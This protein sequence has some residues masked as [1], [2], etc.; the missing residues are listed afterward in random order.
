MFKNKFALVA[1]FALLVMAL[2]ACGDPTATTAPATTAVTSSTTAA[3]NPG[4][5]DTGLP[6]L[7]GAT[8]VTLPD[9]LKQQAS[10][11][12]SAVKNG[13]F[14]AFKIG[15]QPAKVQSSLADS[16]KKAGWDDKSS[17][18]A[19]GADAMKAQGI[20]ILVFQK[21]S[22]IATV[23]GYPGTL[24]GSMGAGVGPNDTFYMVVSGNS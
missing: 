9:V 4:S 8:D 11:Y 21:G 18:L 22:K 13:N 16:F 14:A 15:D 19:A 2:A 5:G 12:T 23:V 20:F 1:L 3:A 17:A 10:A 6:A 24:A 7:S